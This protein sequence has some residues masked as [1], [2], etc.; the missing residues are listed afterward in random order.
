MTIIRLTEKDV[1]EIVKIESENFSDGWNKDMLVS[2]FETGRFNCLAL[3]VDGQIV[4]LI[5]Y[6]LSF[7]TADIEGVVTI[8]EHRG[9]GYGKLLVNDALSK[10]KGDGKEKVFLEVRESNIPAI[11][12]YSS[13]GF[14]KISVRKNYYQDGETALVMVKELV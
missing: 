11:A 9:K 6:S 3:K 7:D 14:N 13:V 8:K 4:G 2:A 1:E 5:T 10:I 12:L